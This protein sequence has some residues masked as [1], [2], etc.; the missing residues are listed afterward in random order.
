MTP[1]ITP[2][3]VSVQIRKVPP[4]A[5]LF[6][7]PPDHP[8]TAPLGSLQAR[9]PPG[10]ELDGGIAA[11]NY[12]PSPIDENSAPC[13]LPYEDHDIMSQARRRPNHQRFRPRPSFHHLAYHHL[14]QLMQLR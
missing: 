11:Y 12:Q 2:S 4:F 14:F 1:S 7:E 9:A 3:V 5:S 6:V 10:L 8:F 13:R